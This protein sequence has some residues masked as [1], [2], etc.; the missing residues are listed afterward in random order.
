MPC[1]LL[2]YPGVKGDSQFTNYKDMIVCETFEMLSGKR[3][4]GGCE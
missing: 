4:G 2:D 1:I 3:D